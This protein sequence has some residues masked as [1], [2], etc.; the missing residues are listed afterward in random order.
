[1]T[2]VM[3]TGEIRVLTPSDP[4]FTAML[5][6]GSALAVVVDVTLRV[7]PQS[8]VRGGEQR[9]MA[10]ETRAQAVAYSHRALRLMKERILP[11]ETVSMELVVAG[12]KVLVA[13]FVFCAAL[14][15]APHAVG[16]LLI[17]TR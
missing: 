1:M 3:V 15:H 4:L 10:F 12:T 13:T 9:V 7:A 14:T 6:A 2:V 17:R 5:G 16:C 8:V 11:D